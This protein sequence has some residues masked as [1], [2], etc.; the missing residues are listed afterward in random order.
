VAAARPPAGGHR[1]RGFAWPPAHRSTRVRARPDR[2]LDP[3]CASRGRPADAEGLGRDDPGACS[4]S[5]RWRTPRRAPAPRS[6]SSAALDRLVLRRRRRAA[7]ADPYPGGAGRPVRG[8][9]LEGVRAGQESARTRSSRCSRPAARGGGG[10]RPGRRAAARDGGRHGDLRPQPQHQL[11]E[12]L[13]VQVPLLRVLQGPAV[14]QPARHALPA[15]AGRHRR[16]LP[17]GMGAGR[18][19]G[20]PAGWHPPELRRRLLRGRGPGREGRRCPRS[21]CTASPP[22]R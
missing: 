5:A 17:G 3:A 11:H 14:A 16:A 19:R 13:H 6:C 15:H 10:G 1:G 2:W 12:R 18:H 8:E 22:W 20:V 7:G 4:P 21:T 9:V